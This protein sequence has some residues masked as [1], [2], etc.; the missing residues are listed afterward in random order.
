VLSPAAGVVATARL[1]ERVGERVNR[2]DLITKVYE[3]S[4]VT[5]EILVSEKE[6]ADVQL[7]QLVAMKARAFPDRNFL[8]AVTAIAP[9]AV[10]DQTGLGGRVVRVM[11]DI[12]NKL[13]LL[14]PDMT[15]SA[16]IYGGSRRIFSLAMRRIVRSVRVEVWSWW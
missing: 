16:K 2:G 9:I 14:K 15:G 6:I 5:A 4:T 7:G 13:G 11:T 8:S 3:Q 12:D 1:K 10:E